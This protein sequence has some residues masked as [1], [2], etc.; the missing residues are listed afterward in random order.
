MPYYNTIEE[1]LER[2]KEILAHGD[3]SPGVALELLQSFVQELEHRH[4]PK[5]CEFRH[6][7]D[8]TLDDVVI[9]TIDLLHLEQMD[10][11]LWWMGLY[12]KA[13]EEIIAF[14]ISS[15]SPVS[16]SVQMDTDTMLERARGA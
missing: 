7:D 15:D 3:D 8:G 6:N 11:N 12:R 1:D 9:T 14:H 16:V 2:A 13:G 10:R 4:H 5:A